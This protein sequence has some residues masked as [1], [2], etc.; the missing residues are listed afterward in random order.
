M[1]LHQIA[2]GSFCSW[3][4]GAFK[5]GR[6]PSSFLWEKVAY[7]LCIYHIAQ[8]AGFPGGGHLEY[9]CEICN[10]PREISEISEKGGEWTDFSTFLLFLSTLYPIVD[11]T[12]FS[13]AYLFIKLIYSLSIDS[14]FIR[15]LHDR[16]WLT[17]R[18]GHA[19]ISITRLPV[20]HSL[21]GE[22]EVQLNREGGRHRDC[23]HCL[24]AKSCPTL[25]W[26]PRTVAH[27]AP[28]SFGFP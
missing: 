18:L 2:L 8:F 5:L 10:D 23:C 4:N 11:V 22:A 27:Q 28:L 25:L 21:A 15:Q 7:F 14:L 16:A 13:C 20:A 3:W 19:E 9:C 12:D 24:V 6:E 17:A 1:N 26:P